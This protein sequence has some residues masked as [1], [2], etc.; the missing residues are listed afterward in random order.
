VDEV[1]KDIQILRSMESILSERMQSF[2]S[3]VSTVSKA[4]PSFDSFQFA[5]GS[6]RQGLDSLFVY[7]EQVISPC[8]CLAFR[9]AA[10]R[11][12]I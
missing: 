8:A 2:S 11:E 9:V 4:R 7:M 1:N 5:D 3:F 12:T 6:L 10:K